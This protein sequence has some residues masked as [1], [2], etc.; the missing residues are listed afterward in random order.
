MNFIWKML[1]NH[2]FP[3]NFVYSFD[4]F[5]HCFLDVFFVKFTSADRL[6]IPVSDFIFVL[7]LKIVHLVYIKV[8]VD[9]VPLETPWANLLI[10]SLGFI[11]E[12]RRFISVLEHSVFV[13]LVSIDRILRVI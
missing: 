7:T 4:I 10:G 13:S 8:Q 9:K 12:F 6:F 3:G 2:L 11:W 1:L 5:F